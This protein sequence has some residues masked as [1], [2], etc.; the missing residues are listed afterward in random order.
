MTKPHDRRRVA[1]PEAHAAL[2]L[3]GLAEAETAPARYDVAREHDRALAEDETAS[4]VT[5]R[6]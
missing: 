5:G 2:R 1:E 6:C 3:I 4:W